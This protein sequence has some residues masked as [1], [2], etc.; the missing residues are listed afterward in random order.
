MYT[1]YRDIHSDLPEYIRMQQYHEQQAGISTSLPV[2]EGG[3]DVYDRF[4][5]LPYFAS[6]MSHAQQPI[7]Q[8]QSHQQ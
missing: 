6:V 5:T 7:H 8:Q 4:Y 3:H 1:Q 2:M